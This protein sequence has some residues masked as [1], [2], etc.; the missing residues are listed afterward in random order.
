MPR[1]KGRNDAAASRKLRAI[2]Q[3]LAAP[4]GGRSGVYFTAVAPS[5]GKQPWLNVLFLCKKLKTLGQKTRLLGCRSPHQWEGKGFGK[6]Y[7]KAFL[8]GNC[9]LCALL[10]EHLGCYIEQSFTIKVDSADSLQCFAENDFDNQLC[11][12]AVDLSP[13]PKPELGVGRSC[14][15]ILYYCRPPRRWERMLFVSV[16]YQR[17]DFL[18]QINFYIFVSRQYPEVGGPLFL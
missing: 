3:H 5:W 13:L 6:L 17:P 14:L 4:K 7:G 16:S 2:L 15:D 10:H 1:A 9:S 11:S 18:N 12:K 8:F